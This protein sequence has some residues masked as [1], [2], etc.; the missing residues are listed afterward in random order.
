M[1]LGEPIGLNDPG[2]MD[3]VAFRPDRADPEPLYRQL[4]RYLE[5]LIRALSPG[6][7]S[8]PREPA[9]CAAR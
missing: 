2:A 4:A 8:S 6:K 7:G 1:D 5:E 3:V 9:T